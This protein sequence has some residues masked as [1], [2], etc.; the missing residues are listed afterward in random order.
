M[1]VCVCVFVLVIHNFLES[2]KADAEEIWSEL[3]AERRD[4]GSEKYKMWKENKQSRKAMGN[5][6]PLSL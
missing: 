5:V 4:G 1:Y 2:I 6:L 3:G